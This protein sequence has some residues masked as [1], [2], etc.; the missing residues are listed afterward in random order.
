[1]R[2]LA[3]ASLRQGHRLFFLDEVPTPFGSREWNGLVTAYP[4]YQGRLLG[5]S[6][7]IQVPQLTLWMVSGNNITLMPEAFRRCL[8][9]RLEPMVDHPEDRTGFRFPDLL[10][11]VREHQ[12]E[13]AGDALTI[14]RAYHF[15]GRPD[16]G[17]TSWGSFEAWS[18]LVRN[19]VFWVTGR[20]CDTRKNLAACADPARQAWEGVMAILRPMLSGSPFT[21]ERVL[22][23][24]QGED[25][26]SVS[27]A[28]G[29]EALNTN[30]KGLC[31]KSLG[32]IFKRHEKVVVDGW[33][34]ARH[35]ARHNGSTVWTLQSIDR[36]MELMQAS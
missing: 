11:Y 30:P 31:G 17:L 10:A 33:F 34:L 20:D 9:I 15:A 7:M 16:F 36:V 6:T 5:Q 18:G 12:R 35:S 24:S 28:A 27:L 19:S 26:L 32:W 23:L 3:L 21:A 25:T 22:G 13:L 14:L 29:L 2:K 4:D 8:H 1:M